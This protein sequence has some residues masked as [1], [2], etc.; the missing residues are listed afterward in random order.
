MEMARS[1]RHGRVRDGRLQRGWQLGARTY[2]ELLVDVAQVAFHRVQRHEHRLGDLGVAHPARGQ[3]GYP[4]L[5][6]G[7]R[8]QP[9]EWGTPW[10]GPGGP[11]LIRGSL[12]EPAG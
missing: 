4:A 7:Q 6:G 1:L 2:G 11:Q 10:P 8:L 3:L 5:A 12:G 9:G